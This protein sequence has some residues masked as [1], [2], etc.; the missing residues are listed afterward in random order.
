MTDDGYRLSKQLAHSI[1]P[2]TVRVI[3][4]NRVATLTDAPVVEKE[5]KQESSI[6]R[7]KEGWMMEKMV[8]RTLE[9]DVPV[10]ERN[11]YKR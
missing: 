3:V 6:F 5:S 4:P 2:F 7:E 8:R 1:S 9:P 11:E 10:A